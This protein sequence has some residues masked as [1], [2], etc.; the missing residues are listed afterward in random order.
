MPIPVPRS[1]KWW[2]L[3]ACWL[4]A[5]LRFRSL[6]ANRFHADE[7]LFA[8]WAREISAW[9]DPLL[10]NQAVDKPPLLF[11]LQALGYTA[12]G[13]AEWA[14]RLPNLVASIL[15]I[16]LT[17]LL[18]W[19][20][21]R[22]PLAAVL[23]ATGLALAPLAIQFSS[24]AFTD[25][26]LMFW[27]L[28]AA[29]LATG[30]AETTQTSGGRAAVSSGLC[31]G[32]AA[33]TKHQAWLFLPLVLAL[34][35]TS[36]WGRA[37]W[38]YWLMGLG[39]VL[40]VLLVWQ[41]ARGEVAG[42]LSQQWSN[43][44]GLRLAW[45]WE[46]LPRLQSYAG[47]W[48][49][50]LGSLSLVV[51][52]GGLVTAAAP[53]GPGTWDRARQIDA[54]LLL[55]LAGYFLLHWA[56][57]AP[58]WDRYLL[59]VL[60]LL[61]IVAG[62]GVAVIAARWRHLEATRRQPMLRYLPPLLLAAML[63]WQLPASVAARQGEFPLGGRSDADDGAAAAARLL[64]DEPYGTVLYD[65]W[66]SWHWRYQLF[67]RRVYVSWF[68]HPAALLEDLAVFSEGDGARFIAL[69]ASDVAL[70]VSRALAA[71]GYGLERVGP[72]AAASPGKV[73]LFRIVPPTG[74]GT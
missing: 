55:F 5:A 44:G 50:S 65:N 48:Q 74:A 19:R 9:F 57:A 34:G 40:I 21:Y 15:A 29:A 47:L 7:A 49:L 51:F 20:L 11:Y 63:V 71:A 10:A 70:P 3:G 54:I 67:N 2:V 4:G 30:P 33:A 22:D 45:S 72:D 58:V 14:A 59:P 62:R 52:A 64:Y 32:L 53:A 42:L 73:T 38:R 36:G 43:V 28:A 13:P 37:Q 27:V 17:G 25:P 68:P 69:P 39:P 46:L 61:L 1:V 31:F 60:P 16:A 66:Y 24:T 26:L 12:L 56:W 18:G 35:F 6:F 8:S 23:P 41:V